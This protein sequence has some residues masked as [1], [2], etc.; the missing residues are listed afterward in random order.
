MSGLCILEVNIEARDEVS[1]LLRPHAS[2]KSWKFSRYM[3][4]CCDNAIILPMRNS[5]NEGS[6]SESASPVGHSR[7]DRVRCRIDAEKSGVRE[8]R[9][10]RFDYIRRARWASSRHHFKLAYE[11]EAKR[12]QDVSSVPS[13]LPKSAASSREATFAEISLGAAI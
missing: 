11:R 10:R 6:D 4:V 7:I 2:S 9:R 13:S 8:T 5:R 1:V 3:Y 12:Y